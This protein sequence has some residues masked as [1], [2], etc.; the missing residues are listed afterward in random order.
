MGLNHKFETVCF[1][2]FPKKG[3]ETDFVVSSHN[4]WQYRVEDMKSVLKPYEIG[5]VKV[6]AGHL[7]REGNDQDL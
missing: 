1:C 2:Q 5:A 3:S 4:V 7:G 6:V